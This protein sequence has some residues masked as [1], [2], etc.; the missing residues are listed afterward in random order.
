MIA[1]HIDYWDGI[2]MAYLPG[3]EGQAIA[4][5]L[6]GEAKFTGKLSMPWYVT[7]DDITSDNP[8]ILFDYGF[9]LN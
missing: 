9:G 3:T 2:V 6:F 1:D 7:V 4:N 8:N 5:L